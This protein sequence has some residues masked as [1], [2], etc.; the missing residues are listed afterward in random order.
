M[1]F[2]SDVKSTTTM[3]PVKTMEGTAQQYI[4]SPRVMIYGVQ[5]RRK[6][7]TIAME[8]LANFVSLW[9]ENVNEKKALAKRLRNF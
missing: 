5:Q 6:A 9:A 4:E 1:G 3:A 2:N 8:I 7:N